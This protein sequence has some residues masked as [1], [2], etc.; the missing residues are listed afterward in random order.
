M[1][2]INPN[3]GSVDLSDGNLTAMMLTTQGQIDG[4]VLENVAFT[5]AS[6]S[7]IGRPSLPD[8][9]IIQVTERSGAEEDGDEELERLRRVQRF[10]PLMRENDRGFG[11]EGFLGIA[12]GKGSSLQDKKEEGLELHPGPL[13]DILLELRGHIEHYKASMQERQEVLL[14]R[15][16]DVDSLSNRSVRDLVIAL[17]QAKTVSD[18]VAESKRMAAQ[19][20]HTQTLAISIFNTLTALGPYLDAEDRPD[21]PCF[22]QKWPELAQLVSAPIVTPSQ[23][24]HTTTGSSTTAAAAATV[25]S[26]TAQESDDGVIS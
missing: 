4:K 14:E 19:A 25:G 26:S 11:L 7:S 13:V 21:S 23:I 8:E 3:A 18:K 6:R 2:T 5:S 16:K 17:N 24:M 10:T 22:A 9:G 12:L 15:M 20:A 1:S